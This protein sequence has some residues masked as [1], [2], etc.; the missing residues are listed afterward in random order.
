MHELLG[1]TW[2]LAKGSWG[3]YF[4]TVSLEVLSEVLCSTG[5]V[6]KRGGRC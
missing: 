4:A 2:V 3:V 5:P 6:D 1:K